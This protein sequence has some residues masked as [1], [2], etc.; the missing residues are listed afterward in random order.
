M[1]L[2]EVQS[3]PD[4]HL[5]EPVQIPITGEL[6]LHTFRPSEIPDLLPEYFDECI[7][8]SIFT[9]RVIH[10]KGT[11][12]LREGVHSLLDRLPQVLSWQHPASATTGSWGATWV[13]LRPDA[14]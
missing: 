12:S 11:G 14:A 8:R 7:K 4:P 9:V 3:A 5:D 2:H 6:D 1:S 10:G 13:Y